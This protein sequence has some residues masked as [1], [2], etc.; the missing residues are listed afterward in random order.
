MANLI[1]RE[2]RHTGRRWP[3]DNGSRDW[4]DVSV[5]QKTSSIVGK[6]QKLEEARKGFLS[7]SL[8]MSMAPLTP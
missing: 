6:H 2:E 8:I 4:I 5:S 7:P 1:K 3:R